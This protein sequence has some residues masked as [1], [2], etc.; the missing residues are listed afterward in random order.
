MQHFTR[1]FL[2][3]VGILLAVTWWSTA[4]SILPLRSEISDEELSLADISSVRL[5]VDPL[6]KTLA[7][8]WG[9][10]RD[11]A[12]LTRRLITD[13]DFTIADDDDLPELVSR[14]A[15]A[16]S[17]GHPDTIAVDHVLALRQRVLVDRLARRLRVPTATIS[18]V[19]LVAPR[20]VKASLEKLI[21]R[22][23][24][25]LKLVVKEA[26]AAKGEQ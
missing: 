19:V 13:A 3:T 16:E 21:R 1:M 7:N 11:Y 17:D 24:H 18:D 26:T 6:P 5:T 15:I 10:S 20:G 2:L 12:K 9:S 23:V 4:K 25:M 22:N 14:V 8:A